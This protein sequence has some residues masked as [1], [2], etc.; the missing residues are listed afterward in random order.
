MNTPCLNSSNH[1]I[2][3]IKKAHSWRNFYRPGNNLNYKTLKAILGQ[4]KPIFEAIKFFLYTDKKVQI[5]KLQ[6]YNIIGS[7]K[8]FLFSVP[9]VF[10]KY[11]LVWK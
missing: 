8:K 9:V 3:I 5:K 2:I 7:K 4:S 11:G 6:K 1:E 10:F